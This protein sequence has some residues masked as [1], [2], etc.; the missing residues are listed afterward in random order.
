MTYNPSSA[1]SA[2]MASCLRAQPNVVS[3]ML[4]S[5][6]LATLWRL[7]TRPTCTPIL[8]CPVSR[9]AWTLAKTCANTKADDITIFTIA[10]EVTDT[11]IKQILK[12]CASAEPYFYDSNNAQQMKDAFKKIGAQLTA[13]RLVY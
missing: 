12:A 11:K 2:S 6:C 1:A 9:P 8:S 4:S 13:R 5:K 3:P 7:M 10:F